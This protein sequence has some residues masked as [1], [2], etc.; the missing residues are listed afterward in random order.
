MQLAAL[1]TLQIAAGRVAVN[2]RVIDSPALNVPAAERTVVDGR[3][4]AAPEP[5]RLWRYHKPAGLVT[6]ERDEK[7]CDTVFALLAA[8]LSVFTLFE[9]ALCTLFEGFAAARC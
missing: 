1:Y 9:G 6:T 5:A 8:D 3:E 2:G 4:F 7:G